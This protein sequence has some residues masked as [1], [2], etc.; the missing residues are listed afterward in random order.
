MSHKNTTMH[1][2]N[3]IS[4]LHTVFRRFTKFIVYSIGLLYD[5]LNLGRIKCYL[6]V[7]IFPHSLCYQMSYQCILL[8]TVTDIIA[9]VVTPHKF[10]SEFQSESVMDSN[11]SIQHQKYQ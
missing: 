2:K 1:Y 4:V 3:I 9:R 6:R 8:L 10:I 7:Y 5:T 11:R